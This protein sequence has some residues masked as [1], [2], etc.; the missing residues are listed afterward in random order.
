MEA[1]GGV[2]S[3]VLARDPLRV[4][5]DPAQDRRSPWTE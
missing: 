2:K 1:D 4:T 5:P 3:S